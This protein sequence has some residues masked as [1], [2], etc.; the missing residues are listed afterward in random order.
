MKAIRLLAHGA[1]GVFEFCDLPEPTPAADE[2]L[3]EVKAC[4][5]NH[6]D[7]WLEEGGLPIPLTLPRIPG[8]EVAGVVTSAG[9]EVKGWH[10][11]QRVAIQSNLFCGTCEY[12]RRGEDS[13]CLN[14]LLL[15]VQRD[16]GFAERIAVPA[17]CLVRLPEGVDFATAAA[18]TLAGSTAMH[19]LT[20][21]TTVKPGDWVLVIGGAS[22][23]GSAAIQI[24]RQLGARVMSTGSTEPK[25]ALAI[26]LGAELALDP[27]DPGWPATVRRHTGKRGA[28]II[29][30]HVG[31]ETLQQALQCL[32]RGGT[33]VTCGATA[34]REVQFNL[35]PFFV[36]QQRLIGSY[37]RNR[38]D[39]E[40]LLDWAA[41]GKIQA[42]I[43]RVIPLRDVPEACALMRQRG[44][45]GKL[46][47]LP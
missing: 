47:I 29:V 23:V 30:E 12:C 15:G 40:T 31:G 1:P 9:R 42:V 32:A 8:A 35:W 17:R 39:L 28:D 11:G 3:I 22:G 10:P 21:R 26:K 6:L 7:L 43:D 20:D 44:V 41:K 13:F 25:R 16:G 19:M 37:G 38:K 46:L 24:A 14:S 36:K 33:I 4:G 5:L 2:V 27:A 45:L 18:L 34:G